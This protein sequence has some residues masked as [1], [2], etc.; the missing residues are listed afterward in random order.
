[1]VGSGMMSIDAQRAAALKAWKVPARIG[2]RVNPKTVARFLGAIG[3]TRALIENFA[4]KV[5]EM[6]GVS[7]GKQPPVWTK[8]ANTEFFD[9][10]STIEN[11]GLRS[12]SDEHGQILVCGVD[13]SKVSMSGVVRQ[14]FPIPGAEVKVPW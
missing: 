4:G 6:Q 10:L 3:Y 14:L 5:A 11:V 7:S 12:Q 9:I 8:E 2:G 13:W 1:M